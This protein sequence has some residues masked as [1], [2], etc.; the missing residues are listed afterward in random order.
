M[1]ELLWFVSRAT[2]TASIVLLTAVLVLGALTAGRRSRALSQT[3]VVGLHRSLALGTSAFLL[4]HIGTAVLETYVSIDWVSAFVPF[5]AGYQPLWVGLGTLAFDIVLAVVATSLLRHRLSRRAWK[6]VHLTAFAL[7][8]LA[9]VHGYAMGTANEP[10]LR[11]VPVAC[12]VVGGLAL[13]WRAVA[14]HADQ[15]RRQAILTQEWS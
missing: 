1:N 13:T 3:V 9:L 7:W 12:A 14:R 6:A 8:P 4:A 11:L 10:L 15:D 5:T 2:G